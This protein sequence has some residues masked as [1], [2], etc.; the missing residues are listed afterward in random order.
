MAVADLVTLRFPGIFHAAHQSHHN[1]VAIKTS[2]PTVLVD[3]VRWNDPM[4]LQVFL[5]RHNLAH[6]T[7]NLKLDTAGPDLSELDINDP[8]SVDAW[9]ELNAI[10]H[11]NWSGVLG[12]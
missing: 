6:Q 3:P 1:I 9:V 2:T 7:V 10:D 8:K 11:Q 4:S 5:L 12:V